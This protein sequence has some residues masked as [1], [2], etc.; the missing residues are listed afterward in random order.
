MTLQVRSRI[1][2]VVDQAVSSDEESM[3]PPPS[4]PPHISRF[5]GDS[6]Q[7]ALGIAVALAG[8]ALIVPLGDNWLR[9]TLGWSD[10]V[11]VLV[12]WVILPSVLALVSAL[13]LRSWWAVL[14]APALLLVG[15]SV[16]ALLQAAWRAS[17]YSVDY[18]AQYLLLGVVMFVYE[19]LLPVT[20]ATV[21]GTAIR[22]LLGAT[23][24]R[25]SVP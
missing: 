10:A 16:G 12:A 2:H 22:R 6:R 7:R 5:G 23:R 15:F 24:T 18:A 11:A 19:V 14:A 25:P 20:I 1:D 13:F 4:Q 3:S 17:V 21:V 9:Q 8:G